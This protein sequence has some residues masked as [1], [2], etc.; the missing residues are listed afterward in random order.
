ML[1]DTLLVELGVV[2]ERSTGFANT[3]EILRSA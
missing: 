3:V 1:E 2:L